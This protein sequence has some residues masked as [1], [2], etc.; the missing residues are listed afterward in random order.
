MKHC[1]QQC[2]PQKT[3][4]FI[5]FR[6]IQVQI[7]LPLK[8]VKRIFQSEKKS[9]PRASQFGVNLLLFFRPNRTWAGKTRDV[10]SKVGEDAISECQAEVMERR[11]NDDGVPPKR[12]DKNPT[13]RRGWK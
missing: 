3:V 7:S 2:C 1:D 4:Y 6:T 13:T 11:K 8:Q 5:N 10:H 12:P 9:F